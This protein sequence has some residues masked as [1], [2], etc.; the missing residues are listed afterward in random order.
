[1][2]NLLGDGTPLA[3]GALM[4]RRPTIPRH[5]RQ[6]EG[7]AFDPPRSVR[8]SDDLW[9]RLQQTASAQ[10]V[11]RSFAL[12]VLARDLGAGKLTPR[13]VTKSSG[14]VRSA[15]ISDQAWEA[16]KAESQRLGILPSQALVGL[17]EEYADG[18]ISI[19]IDITT[20]QHT[21]E[22]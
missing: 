10:G 6:V 21:G 11:T 22:G 3:E 19:R 17:A 13:T 9:R 20:S 8:M 18:L 4:T 5:P 1:M 16:L 12:A 7:D 2:G 14:R 15:R